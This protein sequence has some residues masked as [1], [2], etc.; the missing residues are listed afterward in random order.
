MNDGFGKPSEEPDEEL[1]DSEGHNSK[2]DDEA[3]DGQTP[4][5]KEIFGSTV[6][7]KME[8]FF[9]EVV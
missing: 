2:T 7:K 5:M 4:F 3:E 1:D 6:A 8:D 9:L